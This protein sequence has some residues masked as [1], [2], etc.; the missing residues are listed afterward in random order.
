[1]GK[2]RKLAILG[3]KG[4]ASL[5]PTGSPNWARPKARLGS[6]NHTHPQGHTTDE[7]A[8]VY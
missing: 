6:P 1:M 8:G 4:R 7:R 3:G 2:L 5:K